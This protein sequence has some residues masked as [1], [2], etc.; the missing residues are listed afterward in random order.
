MVDLLNTPAW[1]AVAIAED[2][3]ELLIEMCL[4]ILERKCL[5]CGLPS[6]LY[7]KLSWSLCSAAG[8]VGRAKLKPLSRRASEPYRTALNQQLTSALQ[9][10]VMYLRVHKP[11]TIPA[12]VT[13][14]RTVVSYSD[15][16]GSDYVGVAAA[17]WYAPNQPSVAAYL[18]D[19]QYIR[20]LWP[21]QRQRVWIDLYELEA[22]VPVL[23]LSQWPV[24]MRGTSP[25]HR[26]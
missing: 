25:L 12:S 14:R 3:R 6:Q 17:L 10:W 24:L 19:P 26:Q 9:W 13:Y 20:G 1:F 18:G 11:C 16:E 21:K 2:R 8:R 5:P 7:G 23:I 4:M 15:G 22:T